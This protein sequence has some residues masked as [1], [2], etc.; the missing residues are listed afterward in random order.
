MESVRMIAN[1][2]KDTFK[3]HKFSIKKQ[4]LA[5]VLYIPKDFEVPKSVEIELKI[6]GEMGSKKNPK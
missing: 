4:V 5:G 6:N 3:Y 2:E 1:Y